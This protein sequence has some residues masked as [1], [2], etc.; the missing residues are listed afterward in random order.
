MG[1]IYHPAIPAVLG[2]LALLLIAIP[3]WALI[4]NQRARERGIAAIATIVEKE[5]RPFKGGFHCWVEFAGRRS[6]VAVKKEVWRAVR[7]G[8]S[9]NIRYD[10][11]KPGQLTHGIPN[12]PRSAK[13]HGGLLLA[14]LGAAVI[15]WRLW[16]R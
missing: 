1:V 13:L 14:G 2:F 10:P 3:A 11:E 15:A 7:P 12:P 5:E 4:D 9:L 16:F 6:R 8:E